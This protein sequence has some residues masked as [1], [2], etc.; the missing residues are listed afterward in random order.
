MK[1]TGLNRGMSLFVVFNILFASAGLAVDPETAFQ[2][3]KSIKEHYQEIINLRRFLHMNPELANREFEAAKLVAS[4]LLALGLEI[5]TGIAKTGVTALLRGPQSGQTVAIRADMDALPIQEK[6]DLPYRSLNP[7]VMHACGHDIHTA[8]VLGTAIVLSEMRDKLKGNIKFI[9]QP[10]EEGAPPGEEGGARL[11]VEQGV[12][13]DPEVGAIFGL[14]VWPD[15][16]GKVAYSTGSVMASSDRFNFTI[17]GKNAHG[18]RPNE[19]I[20]AIVIAAHAILSIQ[21][22]VSRLQNPTDP[23][24]ITIG[25]IEGGTRANII[26]DRV[27]F[28]GTVRTLKEQNRSEIE[29]YLEQVVAGA[30]QAFKAGYTFEY[31]RGA[32]SLYNH[33]ELGRTILPSLINVI[34]ESNVSA[35]E[36]QMVAE[37]FSYY[38]QKVPGFYFMLGVTDPRD[39]NP[40]PL[41]NPNFNPDERSIPIGIKIMA[42]LLLDFLDNQQII[43]NDSP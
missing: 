1:M 7:G 17:T 24:V 26:A 20:D 25:T 16:V 34:G 19:G 23:A 9:F 35:I 4:K 6:N 3:E 42:H 40:A 28:E 5:R 18:A 33:P 21:S 22:I 29:R 13:S 11:M 8:V 27:N 10:A 2:I 14:H 37:D 36:P 31:K 12:L 43:E 41:H 32:P 15:R 38:C 30:T 39:R